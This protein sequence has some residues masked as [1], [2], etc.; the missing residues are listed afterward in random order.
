MTSIIF[1]APRV[2]VESAPPCFFWSVC[3]QRAA[4][5]K[6]GRSVCRRCAANLRGVEYP[7][8]DPCAEPLYFTGHTA[9]EALDMLEAEP[10]PVR[11]DHDLVSG[12]T[13]SLRPGSESAQIET[14]SRNL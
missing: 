2:A 8:R 13:P 9:A 4:L 14:D 12:C 10:R 11:E 3:S 5:E 7:V 1:C 6:A